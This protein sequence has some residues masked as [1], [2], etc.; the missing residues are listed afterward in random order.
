VLLG[1]LRRVVLWLVNLARP[2]HTLCLAPRPVLPAR[3]GLTRMLIQ[4]SALRVLRDQRGRQSLTTAYL[5]TT[6]PQ[7]LFLPL[8]TL[9]RPR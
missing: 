2:G 3:T 7:M 4:R 1:L 8:A 9:L 5:R 6:N